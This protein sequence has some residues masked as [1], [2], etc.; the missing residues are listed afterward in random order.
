[1]TAPCALPA[2]SGHRIPTGR[3]DHAVRAD[4]ASALEHGDAGLLV[5][6][7]V[8]VHLGLLC[9][10]RGSVV[11][12]A[13]P[14]RLYAQ[15]GGQRPAR[16]RRGRSPRHLDDRAGARLGLRAGLLLPRDRAKRG[17]ARQARERACSAASGTRSGSKGFDVGASP[18]EFL[19][20]PR[21]PSVIFSTTNGTRAILETA[22]RCR[23][24]SCL[25]SLLNLDAVARA[26]RE[27]GEDVLIVCA[28]FQGEFALDDAY[29]AGRIVQ[30]LGA[31][32]SDA[33]KARTRSPARGRTP[34][35]LLARTYGPPG[36]EEETSRS[37]HR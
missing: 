25:G 30:L 14:R 19:G 21:A 15:G 28:G 17:P 26:A 1:M 34:T 22:S 35:R 31:E 18:R 9:G 37:A 4:A 20:E 2:C 12:D 36:L 10:H 27:R 32:P 6:V 23:R 29:C 13:R 16:D 33:A 8:A 11:G 24:E 3:E 7:P 5:R